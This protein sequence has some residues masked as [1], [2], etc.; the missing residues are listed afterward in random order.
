MKALEQRCISS[1]PPLRRESSEIMYDNGS[2]HN[3]HISW[4]LVVEALILGLLIGGGISECG[5]HIREGLK[6]LTVNVI[7]K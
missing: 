1:A 7:V 6:S 5:K 3:V 4:G 2:K